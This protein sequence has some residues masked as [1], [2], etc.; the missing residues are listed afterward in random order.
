MTSAGAKITVRGVVQGVGFR[1]WCTRIAQEY[2]VA[3]YVANL[4][5]GSVEIEAEADRSI[6]EEFIKAVKV[7]P[8]YAHVADIRIEWLAKPR[9]FKDFSV[10]HRGWV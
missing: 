7:G 5:D 4:P 8:T 1:Y 9:G 2:G 10:K 6:V 3:G